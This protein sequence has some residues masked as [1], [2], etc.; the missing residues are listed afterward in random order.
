MREW[1]GG[2]REKIGKKGRSGS[3]R[4][5]LRLLYLSIGCCQKKIIGKVPPR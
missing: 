3:D 5:Y 2:K 1:E 4:G